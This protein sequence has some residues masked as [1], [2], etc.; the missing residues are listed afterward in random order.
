M[1]F[2]I[3]AGHNPAGKTACGAVGILNESTEARNVKNEVIRQLRA[4]GHEVYDCTVDDGTS[5]GDVLAKIV[6]KCN[7]HTV[8]LDVSIHFNAGAGDLTGNGKTTGVE[9]LVYSTGGV[10]EAAAKKV[11]SSISALGFKNRGVKVNTGL[12]VLRKTAAPAMLIEC[13]FVDD[14]DDA[15]LY[16]C[17]S[18]AG[19]IV[20]G[21][22]GQKNGSMDAP[23]E[24]NGGKKTSA[25]V[26][27]GTQKEKVTYRVQ[28][29]AFS[30]RE[31]AVSL[32]KKLKQKGF[33]SVIVKS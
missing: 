15:G 20:Y 4:L 12:Y 25:T 5:A 27:T 6:K 33:D 26:S 21:L 32:Q 2:N 3:H 22:A 29:G 19:A 28:V 10:P 11:C 31:N 16:D 30:V 8:D 18:M 13:C 1:R 24:E 14:K 23:S 17:Q 9:V 7:M